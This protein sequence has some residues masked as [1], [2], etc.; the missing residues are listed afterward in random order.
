MHK[1][2]LEAEKTRKKRYTL[3]TT[4]VFGFSIVLAVLQLFLSNQLAGYGK[5]A[6][7][8]S[9]KEKSFALENEQLQKQIARETSIA[10]ISQKAKDLALTSPSQFLTI[11]ETGAFA[12]LRQP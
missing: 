9:I 6:A 10:A 1:I 12:L 11:E 4:I 5:M 2:Q 8:L 3:L 7:E